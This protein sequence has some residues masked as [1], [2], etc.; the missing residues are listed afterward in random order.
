MKLPGDHFG[1]KKG[2]ED[3]KWVMAYLSKKIREHERTLDPENPRDLI[4]AYLIEKRKEENL[5]PTS[6]PPHYFT[7]IISLQFLEF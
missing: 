2:I 1:L 5:T 7:G 6:A 3:Q 4:D